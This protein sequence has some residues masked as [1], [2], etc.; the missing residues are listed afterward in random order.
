M[1][2]DGRFFPGQSVMGYVCGGGGKVVHHGVDK[3][4]RTQGVLEV[5]LTRGTQGGG[6]LVSPLE[7]DDTMQG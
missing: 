6:V 4:P 5:P 3:R 1:G 2:Q 7:S